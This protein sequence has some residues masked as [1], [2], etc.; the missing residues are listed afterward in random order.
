MGEKMKNNNDQESIDIMDEATFENIVHEKVLPIVPFII[1]TYSVQELTPLDMDGEGFKYIRYD[2]KQIY[3]NLM[4]VYRSEKSMWTVYEASSSSD[5]P[6]VG[7]GP[8]IEEALEK[9]GL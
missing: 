8:T 5:L 2:E 6:K 7:W 1:G 4:V 3:I 9:A